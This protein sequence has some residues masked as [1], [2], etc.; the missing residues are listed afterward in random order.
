MTPNLTPG[1]LNYYGISA[2]GRPMIQPLQ[3]GARID[4]G[5]EMLQAMQSVINDAALINLF[6]ILVDAPQMT[7]TEVR[8]RMQE[9]GQLI[10]PTVGRAQ[11]EFLG[12]LIEREI[13]ILA[14]QN[15]LPPMPDVLMEAQGE[16]RV[17]YD[18]P[19]NR[20]QKI[21]EV[22]AVDVWLQGLAPLVQLAPEILDN[23]DTDELARHRARTMGVPEK[24]LTNLDVVQERRKAR[25]Q[26]QQAQQMAASAPGLAGAVKDVAEAGAIARGE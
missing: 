7:A 1:G 18:S 15:M 13:D 8:A 3:T 4:I 24:I 25:A 14:R 23:V 6:Q 22:Q 9:K 16:Y 5:L 20:L 10:A 21:E 12:K 17:E 26:Q 19:L 2:E 11:S